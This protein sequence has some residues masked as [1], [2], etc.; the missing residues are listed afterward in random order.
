MYVFNP[1]PFQFLVLATS[2]HSSLSVISSSLV[3]FSVYLNKM[4]SLCSKTVSHRLTCPPPVLQAINELFKSERSYVRSLNSLVH[5]YQNPLKVAA[6]SGLITV[7]LEQLNDVFLN[8][9]VLHVCTRIFPVSL[10]CIKSL[11]SPTC[12]VGL[13][14]YKKHNKSSLIKGTF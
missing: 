7:S 3:N 8:W 6:K 2:S 11:Y 5:L 1:C 4:N 9:W 14:H 12:L 10:Y 13:T